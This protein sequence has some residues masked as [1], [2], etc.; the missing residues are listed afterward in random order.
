MWQEYVTSSCTV[1]SNKMS[2]PTYYDPSI[3][4]KLI[5]LLITLI[6]NLPVIAAERIPTIS[7]GSYVKIAEI[8]KTL[9]DE[10]LTTGL[11]LADK[12]LNKE[13]I[14]DYERAIG[15]GLKGQLL[16]G[17]GQLNESIA[18]YREILIP[19]SY[20]HLTLPTIYSV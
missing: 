11:E 8:Q 17:V 18:I 2:S 12:Y 13:S 19:V 1:L 5:A 14:S 20:T 4:K 9:D 15:L 16:Y 7:S 10:K 6:F 3:L